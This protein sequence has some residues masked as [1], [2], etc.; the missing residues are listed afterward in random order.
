M[1]RPR[2][3]PVC[4]ALLFAVLG[5]SRILLAQAKPT[6]TG[7]GKS[8][9][10]GAGASLYHLEYGDRWLG[11]PEVFADANLWWRLGL[12]GEARWLRYNQDLGTHASTI[13]V[14]PRY[15]FSPRRTEPYLKALVGRGQFFYPYRYAHA[16]YTVVAGGGGVDFHLNNVVQ[17]R[18]VDVEYQ[19]WLNADFNN[20]T[21]Y[22]ISSGI[23]FALF[24]PREH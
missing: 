10:V 3:L 20:G 8:F 23:S 16:N 17:I 22:G 7:P 12:E 19:R 14:G 13:L 21:Q 11:A 18:V 5:T 15:S 2:L 4:C 24:W 9:A 1:T 6:A